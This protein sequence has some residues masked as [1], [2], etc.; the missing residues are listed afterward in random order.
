MKYHHNLPDNPT[1]TI[2]IYDNTLYKWPIAKFHTLTLAA[3]FAAHL[4]VHFTLE[5]D[6]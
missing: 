5:T 2:Y 6:N 4:N 1:Y 3:A